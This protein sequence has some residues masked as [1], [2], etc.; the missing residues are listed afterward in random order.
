MPYL[1]DSYG[2]P[3]ELQQF[4]ASGTRF[5]DRD[6]IALSIGGNDLSGIDLTGHPDQTAYIVASAAGSA[7]R[8]ANWRGAPGG[9]WRPQHR[10]AQ[11]RQLEMVPRADLRR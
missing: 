8:A 1:T 4:A 6:L 2:L 5:T 11:H 7:Q 10:L 9:S 3:Y